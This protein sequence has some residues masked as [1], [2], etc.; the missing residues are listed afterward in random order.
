M[1]KTNKEKLVQM[2]V[3]AAVVHPKAGRWYRTDFK[4]SPRLGVGMSGVKY[5]VKVG[6]GTFG[7]AEEE[8]MEPGVSIFN[9]NPKEDTALSVLACI[10]NKVTVV[11][12]D[13][14]G[15]EGI[16]TGKHN[17][18]LVWFP[19]DVQEKIIPGDEMRVKAWGVGLNITGYEEKVRVN[20]LDPNL[21]EKLGITEENGKLH[22]PVVR[23]YPAWIMGSGY[24]MWPVITDYDIQTTDP[25]IWDEFELKKIRHGDVVCLRDQLNWWG[26]GY[27]EG[28]VTIGIVVHGWSSNQG[29]GPG[30]TSV[31]SSAD[32]TLVPVIDS[33]ANISRYLGIQ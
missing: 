5:N 12:G 17:S 13:A 29:H 15:A 18:F 22:V 30:V 21:L 19:R 27:F 4:G 26:R 11:S 28:A 32:D 2:A 25:S 20:K 6:D 14:K 1:I 3:T 24:G 9:S 8:H 31:L 10:G 7:F 23:E 33:S 16:I